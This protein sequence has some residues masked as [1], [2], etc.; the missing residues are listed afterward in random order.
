MLGSYEPHAPK[1]AFDSDVGEANSL[2]SSKFHVIVLRTNNAHYS[3]TYLHSHRVQCSASHSCHQSKEI[4]CRSRSTLNVERRYE[5][6]KGSKK[7]NRKE[8]IK[9]DDPR[10]SSFVLSS[11]PYRDERTTD[12]KQYLEYWQ[13]E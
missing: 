2:D 10:T 3:A 1:A 6:V 5:I 7:S 12:S 4:Y 8:T 13:Q 11:L 9:V